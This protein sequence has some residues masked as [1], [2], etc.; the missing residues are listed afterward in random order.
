MSTAAITVEGLSKRYRIGLKERAP[1]TMFGAATRWLRAPF[2]NYARLRDL[3]RFQDGVEGDDVLWALRDV[4]FELPRGQVL[5]IIG[6][7]GAGKSTLLKV[8]SRIVEP[9]SG[10]AVMRGRVASLL[11]VGTGFH[12]ELTG[13][14][15]VYLN[16]TILGMTKAEVARKF[17]EI[18]AF[19]GVEKFI[20]TPVKRYSSGMYVRLAFAVA[21]HLDPEILIVDEV[22][23]V[24]DHEFQEKCLGA[25]RSVARAG[26][27]VLFVSHNMAAVKALC[28][29]GMY[30]ASGR[31]AFE[32]DTAATIDAYLSAGAKIATDGAIPDAA[33][34]HSTGEAR[35]THALVVDA[36]GNQTHT[37]HYREP[38]NLRLRLA[39]E[40]EVRHAL[41]DARVTGE[42]LEITHSMVGDRETEPVN[43]Q[44]GTYEITVQLDNPMQPGS[45][46]MT[47]GLHY[48]DGRT[49]DYVE[50]AL[51]LRVLAVA[52]RPQES[53][54]HAWTAGLVRVGGQWN[55]A[56]SHED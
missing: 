24:G 30:M 19:S 10:R 5:G 16:G 33:R 2:E 25:M 47:I 38:I 49:I 7:N 29:R 1:D 20:D 28:S 34:P 11:E 43:L 21:A 39:V 45:Y 54:T 52:R 48:S 4:S 35:F 41:L 36:E 9:S 55:I 13:R 37:V 50:H 8:L 46:S 12:P 31:V 56:R 3:G 26:R 17:D 32:G 15:N 23:A 22:L 53:W 14:D 6:R 42:G 40:R 51:D 27:T 44:P 18:V